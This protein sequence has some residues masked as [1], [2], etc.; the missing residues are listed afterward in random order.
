[1]SALH[2][3]ALNLDMGRYAIFVWPAYGVTAVIFA[4]M[5]IDS[6]ARARRWRRRAE[7]LDKDK[8]P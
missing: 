6:L 1:L 7:D 5:I 4:G 2:L 3:G 8:T